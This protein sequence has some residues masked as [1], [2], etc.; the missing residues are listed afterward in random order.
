ML[1]GKNKVKYKWF[2]QKL[3]LF[4]TGTCSDL[5]CDSLSSSNVALS[6]YFSCFK[7]TYTQNVRN[8]FISSKGYQTNF[9]CPHGETNTN[10]F[11]PSLS[12]SWFL[13]NLQKLFL[14]H[15]E[16]RVCLRRVKYLVSTNKVTF[17]TCVLY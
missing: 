4:M 15:I 3:C 8:Q 6:S 17:I 9:T 2:Y 11:L 1:L 5:I 16:K 10:Y 14:H 13:F 7:T 12:F